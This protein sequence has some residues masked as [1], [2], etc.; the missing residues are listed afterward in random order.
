VWDSEFKL[1]YHQNK[2]KTDVDENMEKL[3]FCSQ[4]VWMKNG[5]AAKESSMETP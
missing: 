2:M 1:Q 3:G 4:L 5:A